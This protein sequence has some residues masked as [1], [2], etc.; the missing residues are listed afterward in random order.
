[1]FFVCSS[2]LFGQYENRRELFMQFEARF[3]LVDYPFVFS[4]DY[5]KFTE[6]GF[7]SEKL[8][9][10]FLDEFI[11]SQGLMPFAFMCDLER[12]SGYRSWFKFT[13]KS[14]I[15]LFV[16]L[17]D[18]EPPCGEAIFLLSYSDNTYNLIDYIKVYASG[19]IEDENQQRKIVF[20][21]SI[22]T[23]NLLTFSSVGQM[24]P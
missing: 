24:Y 15:H 12:F 9:D 1:M 14:D 6:P 4:L 20:V 3:P 8:P 19:Q 5:D 13:Q 11:Y 21:E 2:V 23:E 22:L 18:I 17:A 16:V 7:F 10:I